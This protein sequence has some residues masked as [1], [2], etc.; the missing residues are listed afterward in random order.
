MLEEIPGIGPATRRALINTFG[1]MRAV[2]AADENAVIAAI[3]KKKAT[4]I[5]PYLQS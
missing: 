2:A 3:G 5:K 1:S 4:L